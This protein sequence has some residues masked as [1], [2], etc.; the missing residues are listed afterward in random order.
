MKNEQNK[1]DADNEFSLTRKFIPLFFLG[2]VFI[3]PFLIM[4]TVFKNDGFDLV[5]LVKT[6]AIIPAFFIVLIA[7]KFVMARLVKTWVSAKAKRN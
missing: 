5:L 7:V 6:L 3:N 2:L 4:L 1:S